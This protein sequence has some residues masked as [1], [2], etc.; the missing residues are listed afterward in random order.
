LLV[1]LLLQLQLQLQL[2][3]PLLLPLLSL[4]PRNPVIS[5]EGAL[6]RRSGETPVLALAFAVALASFSVIL[7]EDLLPPPQR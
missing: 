7:E 1:Q 2:Q 6:L 4:N 5:T 3:L